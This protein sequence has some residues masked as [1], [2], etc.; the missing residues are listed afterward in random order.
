MFPANTEGKT[1]INNCKQYVLS[2]RKHW[3]Q[4]NAVHSKTMKNVSK[5]K[6]YY[7]T[8]LISYEGLGRLVCRRG[9][10]PFTLLPLQE[11]LFE[12]LSLILS[13]IGTTSSKLPKGK[14]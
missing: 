14:T 7:N 3:E 2:Y 5:K 9:V 8:D 11:L 10:K 4:Q 13:T 6:L 1:T 12:K